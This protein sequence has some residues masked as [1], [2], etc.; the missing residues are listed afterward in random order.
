MWLRRGSPFQVFSIPF[1]GGR[2]SDDGIFFIDV[3]DV[4]TGSVSSPAMAC[5]V[6]SMERLRRWLGR[7]WPKLVGCGWVRIFFIFCL[8]NQLYFF[9]MFCLYS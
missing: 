7:T 6:L 5:S 9:L 1:A 4:E 8:V 3:V 2:G